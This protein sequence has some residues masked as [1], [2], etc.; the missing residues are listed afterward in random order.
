L[1]ALRGPPNPPVEAL[2]GSQANPACLDANYCGV[3]SAQKPL[4]HLLFGSQQLAAVVHFSCGPEH[5][6]GGM[7]EQTRPPASASRFG[8][9]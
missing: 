6:A 2:R 5:V 3:L 4:M 1:G 7:F 8:S 9:Q